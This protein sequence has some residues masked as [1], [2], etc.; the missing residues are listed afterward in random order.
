MNES[1]PE[2]HDVSLPPLV[3]SASPDVAQAYAIQNSINIHSFVK[4][5]SFIVETAEYCHRDADHG[6]NQVVLP[7]LALSSVCQVC[8]PSEKGQD[9]FARS[10]I[11]PTSG[12]SCR[13]Q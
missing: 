10:N 1:L 7:R 2:H 3:Q 8:A 12:K 6:D 9:A 5:V 13:I 11:E 4:N